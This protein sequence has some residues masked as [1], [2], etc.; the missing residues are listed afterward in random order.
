MAGKGAGFGKVILFGEHFV[1]YGLPA[2][3]SAFNARTTATVTPSSKYELA[4]NRPETPGYKKE[5]YGEQLESMSKIFTA[6][7][8][9]PKKTPIMIELGGDLVAA[10][11]VGA[12]AASCTAIARALSQHFGLNLDDNKINAIAY[13]GEKGYHGTPSG[14][15]NTVSTFGGLIWYV[16][17]TPPIFEQIRIPKPLEIVVANTGISAST[18]EVVADVKKRKEAEP[19]KFEEI[20]NEYTAV[21]HNAR[22]ALEAGDVVRI[23]GLMNKN[24]MLLQRAGVSCDELDS[25]VEIALRNGAPGAKMTGTGRG[26]SAIALTPGEALQGNVAAALESEGFEVLKTKIGVML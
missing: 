17:G 20:F 18:T 1:V 24:H 4:D 2:V 3:A 12:S 9:D 7:N 23:G 26:G 10:S 11:G 16:K 21:V 15:D 25:I 14:I 8:I 5:K 19:Q 6:M 13:E 22:K